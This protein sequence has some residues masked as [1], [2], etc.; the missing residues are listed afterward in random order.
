MARADLWAATI[1]AAS[2]DTPSWIPAFHL[3]QAG[4][5]A[6][7]AFLV[8]REMQV[9]RS[10]DRAWLCEGH[11]DLAAWAGRLAP[12][13][14]GAVVQRYPGDEGADIDLIEA[15]GVVEE[16]LLWV[17]TVLLAPA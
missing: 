13:T 4:E 15:Q 9:P 2:V 16:L 1:L 12:L 8:S 5:K 7:K 17:G 3:Q 10:H 11:V 14:D 6:I